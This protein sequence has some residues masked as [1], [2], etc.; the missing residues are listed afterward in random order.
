MFPHA[1]QHPIPSVFRIGQRLSSS[2]CNKSLVCR[3]GRNSRIVPA[4]AVAIYIISM[5]AMNSRIG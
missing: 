5:R 2:T 3:R 4:S 1:G